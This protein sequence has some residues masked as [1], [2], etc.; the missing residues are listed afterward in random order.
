MSLRKCFCFVFSLALVLLLPACRTTPA[1]EPAGVSAVPPELLEQSYL[2][3]IV[4]YI[5]RWQLDESEVERI[6]GQ[7][8]FVLWVRRLDP[9]LDP[10][11]RSRLA[12]ILLPQL[13]ITVKVKQ[14]DYTIDELGVTVKSPDFRITRISRG[15]LP[16][17]PP[18]A[19][20]TVKVDMQTMR[21]YLFRTRSQHDYPGPALI[22]RL[23]NALRKEAAK[24][25]I[26]ATNALTQEQVVHVAPL[27]PVA[28]DIWV[29]WEAGR[30]LFYF[31]SDID[32][33]NPAVWEHQSL[34]VHIFDLDQQVV[35]S[36]EEAPG[37]NRFL[38]RYQVS[39]TLFN[40]IIFG[41]RIVVP[42]RTQL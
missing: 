34:M 41:Q 9:K 38:T 13:G 31:A 42:P 28:N 35:V 7:K 32:L 25:G 37:S 18:R 39:R 14:A 23:R 21:D 3:E 26:L 6:V 33:A 17:R 2:F 15:Q 22:E 11:D 24:Q 16:D 20:T 19:C 12:E 4:R 40:C 30:K 1:P 27:S 8:Q 5:Y 10:G 36:H 29:F